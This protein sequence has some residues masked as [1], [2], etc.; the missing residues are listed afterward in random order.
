MLGHKLGK[1]YF[2]RTCWSQFNQ[3][4]FFYEL[5]SLRRDVKS[6]LN[7]IGQ[8]GK[9]PNWYEIVIATKSFLCLGDETKLKKLIDNGADINI[10]I[11]SDGR[12]AI[13]LAAERGKHYWY[14]S[15]YDRTLKMCVGYGNIVRLL[16][17]S[18]VDVDD[19]RNNGCS[20]LHEAV[21]GGHEHVAKLLIQKGANLN[22]KDDK[23]C[24]PLHIVAQKG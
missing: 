8:N 5:H 3:I 1:F 12:T 7:D 11:D 21:S 20:A 18:G 16:I 24:T 15:W 23:G 19:R 10:V 9:P 14:I 17:D 22:I 4:A 2:L 6:D 13:H